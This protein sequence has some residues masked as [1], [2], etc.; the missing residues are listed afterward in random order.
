MAEVDTKVGNPWYVTDSRLPWNTSSIPTKYQTKVIRNKERKG[1]S[2]QSRRFGAEDSQVARIPPPRQRRTPAPN[3]YSLQSSLLLK[4]SFSRSGSCGFQLPIAVATES[5]KNAT[6]APNHYQVSFSGVEKNTALSTQSVFLSRTGRSDLYSGTSNGP[7]PCQYR[8]TDAITRP[9]PRIP[10]SCF[11]SSSVRIPSLVMSQGPGPGTYSPHEPPE[12]PKRT[13]LPRGH[14]LGL[15]AH[16][17][18]IPKAPPLP[19][20]GQYSIA[21]YGTPP[22]LFMSSAVFMSRTSRLVR[23][24]QG[25][26]SPGP[27]FYDPVKSVKRSFLY[28]HLNKW[29][30]A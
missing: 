26:G 16:A 21:T 25:Q 12:P 1:F 15:A 8:V 18:P 28:N 2:I 23:A 11:R 22:K 19:G 3:A 4:H 10:I 13:V 27:G 20:P 17:V 29:V 6:P 7:S 14:Y 30:P 9:A 24:D 5:I